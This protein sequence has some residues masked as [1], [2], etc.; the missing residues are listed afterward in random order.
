MFIFHTEISDI[1]ASSGSTE[2]GQLLTVTGAHF[3]NGSR[4]YPAKVM[5]GDQ[6]CPVKEINADLTE[7]VCETPSEPAA[8]PNVYTG[9]Y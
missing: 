9:E 1:S 6:N 7:I 5:I 2:G 8:T 4:Q 3:S